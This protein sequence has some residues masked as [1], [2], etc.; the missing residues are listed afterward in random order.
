MGCDMWVL[1]GLPGLGLAT[2]TLVYSVIRQPPRTGVWV[3]SAED[4]QNALWLDQHC[5]VLGKPYRVIYRDEV[6]PELFARLRR[7]CFGLPS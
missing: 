3:I 5:V 2:L 4:I 7:R 1:V 6:A